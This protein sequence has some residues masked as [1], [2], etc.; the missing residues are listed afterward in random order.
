MYIRVKDIC[1]SKNLLMEDLASKLGITRAT[2]TRNIN[3][4]PTVET[5][6]K[7]ASALDVPFVDLFECTCNVPPSGLIA[8][9]KCGA[10]IKLSAEAASGF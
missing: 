9:L 8:C 6:E 3:G 10:I 4:N 5:L 1:K 2:L 7:L